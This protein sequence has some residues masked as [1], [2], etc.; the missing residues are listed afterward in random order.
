MLGLMPF[1]FLFSIYHTYVLS[2]PGGV[3]RK[4]KR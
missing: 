2:F 3:S 1:G 4:V